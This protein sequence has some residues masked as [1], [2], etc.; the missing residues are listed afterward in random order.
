M[1]TTNSTLKY[2]VTKLEKKVD[3][4]CGDLNRLTTNHIPH[5]QEEIAGIKG[6]VKALKIRIDLLTMINV[7]A[8]V[9]GLIFSKLL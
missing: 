3:D 8:I 5:I 6:D 1:S 9:L 2:R 7:A 4:L